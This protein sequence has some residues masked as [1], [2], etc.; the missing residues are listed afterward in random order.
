MNA[1]AVPLLRTLQNPA[2]YGHPVGDFKV[3]ETHISWVI[4]T[5][6]F[7]YK[8]KKPVN[9]GF[10][11]FSTLEKRR[12]YCE[13]E[14]R[15][16]RRLCPTIYEGVV[17]LTGSPSH[18]TMSGEGP[19]FEYMV[20]M[21]QFDQQLLWDRMA[22]RNELT[23]DL[24]TTL[25]AKVASFHRAAAVASTDSLFGR[26]N[27]F[28]NGVELTLRQIVP[29]LAHAEDR[30]LYDQVAAWNEAEFRKLAPRMED[31]LRSGFVREGHG[32]LHLRNIAL[33]SRTEPDILLFDA[34][35]FDEKLRWIDVINDIAFLIMDLEHRSHSELGWRFLNT[36]LEITGDYQGIELMRFYA[37]NRALVRCKVLAIQKRE[38]QP[39]DGKCDLLLESR[40]FMRLAQRFTETKRPCLYITHGL[41]GSG[42]TTFTTDFAVK[43]GAIRVRSDIERKRL[44]GL[45]PDASSSE[46]LKKDMYGSAGNERTYG[47]MKELAAL[48][49]QAGYSAIIDAAFLRLKH[50]QDFHAL[51]DHYKAEFKILDFR[52][53]EETL[54]Q[55]IRIRT[56]ERKDA[57]EADLKVLAD[58][59]RTHEEISEEEMP[60]VTP[61]EKSAT[62]VP[63]STR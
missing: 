7:A 5:G 57:S 48:L 17:P 24:L 20:K 55:R 6:P 59:M 10:L 33:F 45:A 40:Q 34:I 22:E 18:P 46:E 25:A 28:W 14:V 32:D 19:A 13:E 58:Q 47:R 9:L 23:G 44:F 39:A 35:E 15:I 60:F 27:T 16:N 26:P 50:R 36:Y 4:L 38:E 3:V 61:I 30:T 51:A 54:R 53:D 29:S 43:V 1:M 52:A 11:D 31:R 62:T 41:S 37:L 12:H 42:K 56:H 2:I 63:V 21:K 49:L 8:I